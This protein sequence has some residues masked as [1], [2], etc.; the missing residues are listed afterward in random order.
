MD[1][2]IYSSLLLLSITHLEGLVSYGLTMSGA[3]RLAHRLDLASRVVIP[4]SFL[5]LLTW[6]LVANG[7]K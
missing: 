2:F 3:D 7:H 4:A 1:F 5:S 6:Y